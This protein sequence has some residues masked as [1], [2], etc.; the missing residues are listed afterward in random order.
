MPA[1][2]TPTLPGSARAR[3]GLKSVVL[4]LFFLAATTISAR[5][6]E[7]GARAELRRDHEIQRLQIGTLGIPDFVRGVLSAPVLAGDEATATIAFLT[8]HKEL[9]G[10]AA[11]AAEL[12]LVATERDDLGITHLRFRQLHAGTPV[13]HSDL[14]AHFGPDRVLRLVNG[15]L[16]PSIAAPT[17]PSITADAARAQVAAELAV[18]PE[19]ATAELVIARHEESYRLAWCV[20]AR[21]H[22]PP[23]R[24]EYLVD[25]VTGETLV[26]MNR[27]I[28]TDGPAIG[29]GRGVLGDTK[30]HID[31]YFENGRY[32]LDDRSRR[33]SNNVHGHDG[34]MPDTSSIRTYFYSFHPPGELLTDS[35][36][37]WTSPGQ[38]PGVDAH[39]Y[40]AAVYDFLR[41]NVELNGFDGA[42][43]SFIS[44]VGDASC[45]NN[46]YW[47]GTAVN[48]CTVSSAYHSMAGSLDIVAHEWGHAVT[49]H[50]SNLVYARESGALNESYS[51]MLGIRLRHAAGDPTWRVGEHFNGIGF[52]DLANPRTFGDPECY[53]CPG[54]I[55]VDACSPIENNDFCGV[56]TNSGV[57][58]KMFHLLAAGGS[59]NGRPV[60]GIGIDDAFKIVHR[61]NRF[62]WTE[63]STLVAAKAGSLEAA[64]DLDPTGGFETSTHAAWDAVLVGVPANQAPVPV[65]GGPYAAQVGAPVAFDAT[66]SYDPDGRIVSYIWDFGND[67]FGQGARPVAVY[68]TA[69][70]YVAVL[71]VMDNMNVQATATTMVEI[72]TPS[73]VALAGTSLT[74]DAGTVI[75]RWRTAREIDHAGFHLARRGQG[76]G[77]FTRITTGLILAAAGATAHAYEFVDRGVAPGATYEYRLEAVDRS[78][79][80]EFFA[81]GAVLVPAA[82][83]T[84]LALHPS[85]PN[86]FHPP[87]ARTTISFDLPAPARVTVRIY[88]SAGRLAR[89][90]IES[91]PLA[92]GTQAVEWDGRNAAGLALEAGVYFCRLETGSAALTRKLVLIE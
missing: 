30:N 3:P 35:D 34:A 64:A 83:P 13:F 32:A 26:R 29:T 60:T 6:D 5:A 42:G 43:S 72:G 82:T 70:S 84:A 24:W 8:L 7:A 4:T 50:A 52:R 41:A 89:V 28:S 55:D 68:T 19:T 23:G 16:F 90:L 71:L 66:G 40:A 79:G 21:T 76:G 78:G 59:L 33:A 48:Y 65:P 88:D 12:E 69:G 2:T 46:A 27:I 56:H 14:R 67:T 92:A 1:E 63:G 75:V 18:S 17:T 22:A 20:R 61:A 57:P 85:R 47:D 10:L 9:F 74:P 39:V 25:A 77:D 44:T 31:T 86:P 36:N 87:H 58:N 37:Q 62:Y 38:A 80:S 51:D 73:A 45:Q 15:E 11:P 49:E 54:W 53:R 81:L 91:A